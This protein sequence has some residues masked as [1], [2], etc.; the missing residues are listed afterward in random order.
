MAGSTGFTRTFLAL[1]MIE[2]QQR[3]LG[4]VI[5]R[6][7]RDL[8]SLRW[9]NPAGIHLTLAFLAELDEKRLA[10]AMEAARVTAQDFPTFTY[11]LKGLGVFDSRKQARVIWMGVEDQPSPFLQGSPL[12]TLHR[13]LNRE[14]QRRG[15]EV[16]A[17][18]FSPHLTLA[19]IK[20]PLSPAEQ[21]ALERQ[22]HSK[23][24]QTSSTL[25]HAHQLCVMKSEL[26]RMGSR[27]TLLQGY[28]LQ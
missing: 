13:N 4:A 9:V 6:A 18:P 7:A 10:Q 15:F 28:N 26:S 27:Y 21:Q 20:Q 2:E 11:R 16:E 1:D 19:R 14:L 5:E 8:P 3:F 23:Q 24:A 25:Y 17:R 22:L 12:Q